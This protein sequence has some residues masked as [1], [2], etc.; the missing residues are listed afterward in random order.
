MD[1]RFTVAVLADVHGNY[2]A[3]D[4]VIGDLSSLNPD[5]CIFAGDIV[6]GGAKPRECL[7]GMAK[8]G[9]SG[10]LGNMD[11]KVASPVC[12]MTEWTHRQLAKADVGLLESLPLCQRVTPPGGVAPVDD[13][14]V[15]HS[16]PRSCRDLLWGRPLAASDIIRSQTNR[17]FF[18]RHSVFLRGSNL[19]GQFIKQLADT[20]SVSL[21]K[22]GSQCSAAV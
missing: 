5:R 17:S 13:L 6:S 8:L 7:G 1:D 22:Y 20:L 16:T 9:A 11:E 3:L 12:E 4:A 14:L 21:D 10:V 19:R 2:H 15:V 18:S